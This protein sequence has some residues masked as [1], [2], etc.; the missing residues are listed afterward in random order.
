MKIRFYNTPNSSWYV[1]TNYKKGHYLSFYFLT[2]CIALYW[3]PN[4]R[5]IP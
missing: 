5:F 4:S 3:G 2:K 1:G